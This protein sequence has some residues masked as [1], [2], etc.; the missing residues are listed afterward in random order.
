MGM[1]LS[2][3]QQP[4][5]NGG[6]SLC[7]DD[8]AFFN[9]LRSDDISLLAIYIMQQSDQSGAIWIVLDTCYSCWNILFIPLE[10]DH[11]EFFLMP[12]PFMATGNMAV[13]IAAVGSALRREQ[14][15]RSFFLR[16]VELEMLWAERVF[17]ARE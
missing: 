15:F 17:A 6:S 11:A 14:R 9:S 4:I 3:M 1:N 2:L 13:V 10:I 16:W 12:A 8:I 7:R 5:L